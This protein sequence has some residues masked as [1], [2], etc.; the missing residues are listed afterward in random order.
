ML[1]YLLFILAVIII[2]S[3]KK[4]EKMDNITTIV[5]GIESVGPTQENVTLKKG[6]EIT[7]VLKYDLILPMGSI[8]RLIDNVFTGIQSM[9]DIQIKPGNN[10]KIEDVKQMPEDVKQMPPKQPEPVKQM[11]VKQMPVKQMPALTKLKFW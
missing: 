6:T 11:P 9:I 10:I 2:F 4:K 7:I 8:R 1:Y 3:I 5:K